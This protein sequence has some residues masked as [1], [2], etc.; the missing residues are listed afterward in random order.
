MWKE[1]ALILIGVV[2][3]GVYFYKTKKPEVTNVAGDLIEEQKL[4]DNSKFKAKKGMFG[5]LKRDPD[6]KA[7]R[8]AKRILKNE[9]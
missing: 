9:K 2:A 1:L 5:F 8:K 4:K 6:K 7:A 3:C